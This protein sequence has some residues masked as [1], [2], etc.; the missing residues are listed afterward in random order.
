M[1]PGL[2]LVQVVMAGLVAQRQRPQVVRPEVRA[3]SGVLV[4]AP[5]AVV[6]TAVRAAPQVQ[7]APVPSPLGAR[8]VRAV[9]VARLV[10][11]ARVVRAAVPLRTA[12]QH[13][14]L[15]EMAATVV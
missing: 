15:V 11:A 6:V 9:K 8:V 4:G 12:L 10:W 7:L 5:A 14:P 2:A 13:K 3:A 1:A